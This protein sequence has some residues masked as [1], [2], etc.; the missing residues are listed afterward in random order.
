MRRSLEVKHARSPNIRLRLSEIIYF[1]GAAINDI[2]AQTGSHGTVHRF[3]LS[4]SGPEELDKI[5]A[6]LWEAGFP[7]K[8]VENPS[9]A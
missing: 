9:N 8:E 4:F 5:K 6:K 1:C 3:D 2:K 7:A